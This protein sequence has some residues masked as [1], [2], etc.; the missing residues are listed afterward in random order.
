[1][2][3]RDLMTRNP[4]TITPR[5]GLRQAMELMQEHGVRHLPVVR[6]GAL[7]GVLSDRDLLG[8]TGWRVDDAWLASSV[9][10]DA[11]TEG[12]VAVSPDD[13]VVTASVELTCRG[14]GCLPVVDDRELSGM[15]TD[16]DLLRAL[17]ETGVGAD[18]KVAE[19]MTPD[20]RTVAPSDTLID[21][22][23]ILREVG[24]RHLP[25]LNGEQLV[26]IL[27][28]RDV[29]RARGRRAD[30]DSP[31]DAIATSPVATVGAE[32]KLQQA[33]ELMVTRKVSGLP[34]LGNGRVVGIVTSTDVLDFCTEFLRESESS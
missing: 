34:V 31:V 32:A 18:T 20:P 33:A 12:P 19:V 22:E 2:N 8:A 21:A 24:A 9:V 13:S 5:D 3:V 1:M 26:A 23:A 29:Q 14:L 25:V 7:V 17:V 30:G 15:L 4:V 11:M 27:S 10:A 28:D 16:I 6:D